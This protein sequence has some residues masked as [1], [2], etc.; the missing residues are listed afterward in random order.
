MK[1]IISAIRRLQLPSIFI[2]ALGS[3]ISLVAVANGKFTTNNSPNPV[4]RGQY[5][6]CTHIN[7]ITGELPMRTAKYTMD[8][9]DGHGNDVNCV[10]TSNRKS[11]DLNLV[12]SGSGGC[13]NLTNFNPNVKAYRLRSKTDA[14]YI[15]SKASSDNIN[16]T[17]FYK[18]DGDGTRLSVDASSTAQGTNVFCH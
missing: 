1:K 2:L 7:T 11:M 6:I 10:T 13:T 14:S 4:A 15:C 9:K 5:A 3:I 17:K 8:C 12:D 16:A 18:I